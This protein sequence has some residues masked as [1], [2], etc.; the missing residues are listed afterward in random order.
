MNF[1]NNNDGHRKIVLN[2][3]NSEIY[4]LDTFLVYETYTDKC[5]MRSILIVIRINVECSELISINGSESLWFSAVKE[6]D[7]LHVDIT[8]KISNMNLARIIIYSRI[9]ELLA[10][11]QELKLINTSNYNQ[12]QIPIDFFHDMIR[13]ILFISQM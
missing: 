11:F 10:K 4:V 6:N 5:K 7:V 1:S 3:S 2:T 12:N 8:K 9:G 13:M